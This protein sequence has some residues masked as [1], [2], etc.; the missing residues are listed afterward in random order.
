MN[1]I[2]MASKVIRIL[3]VEECPQDV[4]LI[5]DYL[6]EGQPSFVVNNLRFELEAVGR[7]QAALEELSQKQFDVVLTDIA[8]PDCQGMDA[9]IRLQ[10]KFPSLPIIVASNAQADLNS[11]IQAVQLGAQDYI[12]KDHLNRDI[13]ARSIWYAIERKKTEQELVAA[14]ELMENAA[15][16][17]SEF[18]ANMSHELRTPLNSVIGFSNILLKN[19]QKSI[20]EQEL[21]YLQRILANGKHLL[22]LVNE[23]LDLSKIEAGKSKLESAPVSLEF[24]IREIIHQLEGQVLEKPVKLHAQVPKSLG[25][26]QTDAAKLK[27]ILMNLMGNAIKFTREGSVTVRVQEEPETHRPRCIEVIDTGIGIQEEKFSEIFEPFKQGDSSAT[28][29][30]EGTGLGLT[31][32]KSLCQLMGYR[33]EVSSG[34]GKGS[35]FT[36]VLDDHSE[37]PIQKVPRSER[38]VS[39]RATARVSGEDDI[40]KQQAR[41]KGKVVLVIDNEPDARILLTQTI[42]EFGCQ[43]ITATSAE[44]AIAAASK[45]KPDIITLDL[46]MPGT[47]GW[48]LFKRL[49]SHPEIKNIP[50]VVVSIVAKES[51]GLLLGVDDFIDKPITRESLFWS[52]YR[53]LRAGV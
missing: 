10:E 25:M 22:E 11:A 28:R 50:V 24:L 34:L 38:R 41:L 20:S 46:L 42:E 9:V 33:L 15:R 5:R 40:S 27:Q 13:L 16:T 3:L 23:V 44:E 14:K 1:K 30:F 18:L 49:K 21:I 32:A 47:N 39:Y 7:L 17:K 29:E 8:L 51:K 19:K 37:S 12:L 31:I 6:N 43:V 52:L 36:I 45:Y 48:E 26:I 4:Q 2:E 53:N 35:T